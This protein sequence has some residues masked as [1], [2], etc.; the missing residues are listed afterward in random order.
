MTSHVYWIVWVVSLFVT[1][2]N[3]IIALLK[4]DKKYYVL[5]TT[6]QHLLSEGWQYIELSG[7]YSGFYTQGIGPTHENQ[8]IFFCNTLEKIRMRHIQDEYYKV[9]EHPSQQTLA[10]VP[11]S[12]LK[13]LPFASFRMEKS[14]HQLNG[15]TT[16][17]KHD[18]QTKEDDSSSENIDVDA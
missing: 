17:R 5:N 11:P 7:K 13:P 4:I 1:I 16:V 6:Y 9:E 12:P 2:S 10:I 18:P 15:L 14:N 8:F 3:G